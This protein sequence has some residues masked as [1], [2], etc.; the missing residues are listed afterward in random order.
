MTELPPPGDEL[1]VCP[2]C[3]TINHPNVVICVG[4]GIRL[5]TYDEIKQQWQERQNEKNLDRL[6]QL[7]TSADL[8]IQ[9]EVKQGRQDFRRLLLILLAVT[10][11]LIVLVWCAA[12][13]L[14]YRHQLQLQQLN[15]QYQQG[16]TCFDRGDYLC[17]RDAF[18]LVFREDAGYMD[19]KQRLASA[20]IALAKQYLRGGQTAQALQEME[21]V[22]QLEPDSPDVLQGVFELR[23]LL[24]EQ[25]AAS[26]RWQDAIGQLDQALVIR[27][28]D[29]NTL[30]QM[31]NIY[32]RWYAQT[33]A[34]GDLLNAW[35]I[36]RNLKAR[37]PD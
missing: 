29:A 18:V 37:F 36:R 19:S 31:K 2:N 14:N 15:A 10:A 4:C 17:A 25:Y 6:N 5:N 3:K 30:R 22:Q 11:G 28:G 12:A 33:L 26:D 34:K 9:K 20:K 24:A 35:L 16:V 13:L 27:P 21:Q 32:E 23:T 1:S 7:Q 8:T